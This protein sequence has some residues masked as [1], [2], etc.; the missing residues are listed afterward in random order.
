M[1]FFHFLYRAAH[2]AM[3]LPPRIAELSAAGWALTRPFNCLI[4]AFSVGVGALPS[5]GL[6]VSPQVVAAAASA[7]LIAAAGN[8]YNDLRDLEIDRINR[9]NRPLPS[10]RMSTRA[11][12]TQAATLG[13][14]GWLLS[15]WLSP[16]L[17]TMAT[18]VAVGPVSYTHLTLPTKA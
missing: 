1:I 5:G 12:A 17:W 16:Y 2:R 4:T 10:G 3:S 6:A 15:F 14:A 8:V 13:L 9:P 18:G 7:A 11:A